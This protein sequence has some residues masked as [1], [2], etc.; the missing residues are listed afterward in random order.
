MTEKRAI[1]QGSMRTLVDETGPARD[2]LRGREAQQVGWMRP[3]ETM[4]RLYVRRF[5]R[6]RLAMACTIVLLIL[7]GVCFVVPVFVPEIAAN[8]LDFEGMFAP[9]S[10][11]HPFGM[12]AVGRDVLM[13]C[14]YGGRISLRI[15]ILA[16]MIAVSIGVTVGAI[17]GYNVGLIDN[18]LMRFTEALM[19]IPTL[20]ILIVLGR[21][22]GPSIAI[23]TVI[24]GGLAWM[25][26]ARIIRAEILSLKEQDF[27]LAARATGVPSGRILVRHL[28]PNVIAP[29]V[30][31]A[32]LGVGQ[33]IIM[34]AS[35]SFLG[36]GVQPPTATW[37][38]M[39]TRAQGHLRNAP[40]IAVFPGLLILITVLCI[41]FIGDGLRDAMDP[42]ALR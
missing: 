14:I 22:L 15:G 18:I 2:K 27:V 35:L 8:I 24:L 21:V 10:W 19:S 39:L 13:R 38:S 17:C 9:P 37:G 26:T 6:H 32:T 16:A 34:E 29:I 5:L 36:L 3:E 33:A 23:I 42:H 31:S 41:N 20:F 1:T 12:D 4:L 40:W 7:V 28:I 11:E 25:G 30:V